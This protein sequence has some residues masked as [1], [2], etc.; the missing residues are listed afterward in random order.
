MRAVEALAVLAPSSYLF[1]IDP[2][3]DVRRPPARVV[4]RFRRRH[5]VLATVGSTRPQVVLFSL[6]RTNP[7]YNCDSSWPRARS[8]RVPKTSLSRMGPAKPNG[9]RSWPSRRLH[10]RLVQWLGA[11]RRNG[12]GQPGRTVLTAGRVGGTHGLCSS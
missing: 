7:E 9:S 4:V 10:T 8:G 6:N 11:I 5:D 2:F 3:P 12:P 1:R